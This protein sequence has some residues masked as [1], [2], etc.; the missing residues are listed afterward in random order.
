MIKLNVIDRSAAPRLYYSGG[1]PMLVL[2]DSVRCER[3]E[4][5]LRLVVGNYAHNFNKQGEY[6]GSEKM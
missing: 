2:D 6:V 3:T 1:S 5:G 4:T